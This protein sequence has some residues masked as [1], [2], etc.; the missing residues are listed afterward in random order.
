[1]IP[2]VFH[3]FIRIFDLKDS[4]IWR[5]SRCAEVVTSPNS[6]HFL[7]FGQVGSQG[8]P[9]THNFMEI[10]S[11]QIIQLL[12]QFLKEQKL[13]SSFEVLQKETGIAFGA[14]DNNSIF[15]N[16]RKGN[17]V[18]VLGELQSLALNPKHLIDL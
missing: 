5:I 18:L 8:F 15:E 13:Q 14:V 11:S 1:M 3:R 9:L 4:A 2:A 10:P 12:L 17:W 7:G 6:C 16:I